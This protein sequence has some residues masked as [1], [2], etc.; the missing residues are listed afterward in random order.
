MTQQLRVSG[1]MLGAKRVIAPMAFDPHVERGRDTATQVL[2]A[3]EAGNSPKAVA[4]I[5]TWQ[6]ESE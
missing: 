3:I 5:E 4:L 6:H 1:A 2:T